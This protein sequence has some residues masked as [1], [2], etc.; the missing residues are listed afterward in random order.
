MSLCVGQV[1]DLFRQLCLD[2]DKIMQLMSLGF[3]EQDA[4]LGLRACRGDLSEAVEH[5]TQ[6]KKVLRYK[7]INDQH[8]QSCELNMN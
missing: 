7:H 3:S 8:F 1:E 5:I 2:P 6:R 4:R